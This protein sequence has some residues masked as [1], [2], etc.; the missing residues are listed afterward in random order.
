MESRLQQKYKKEVIPAL[1]EKFHYANVLAV[2]KIKKVSLNVG[3][4]SKNTESNYL[5]NV[6]GTLTKISG[7]K[8]IRAKAKKAISAFK[9][10]ENMIVGVNVTLR[11][12]RMYD[13][14][15]KLINVSLPRV[16][17][18]RGISEKNIDGQGNLS[19]GFKE[20]IV[21]PEIKPDEVDRIHG[22]EVTINTSAQSKEEGKEL[23]QLLGF[24]FQ[25]KIIK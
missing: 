5:D 7:Q 9:V 11:G 3:V 19:L 1:Q 8:P 15:D 12:R 24:P 25:K 10:K 20:H 21:F 4:N 6:E 17:D 13:F 2:P 22:L 23:F 16:R 18:F 14:L